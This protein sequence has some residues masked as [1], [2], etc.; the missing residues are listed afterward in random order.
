MVMLMVGVSN[1][2]EEEGGWE[3]VQDGGSKKRRRLTEVW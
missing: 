3:A 2:Q 1:L